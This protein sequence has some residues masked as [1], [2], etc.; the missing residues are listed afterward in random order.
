[1]HSPLLTREETT[2]AALSEPL[3]RAIALL[4]AEPLRL[5]VR[6]AEH[7]LRDVETRLG[8]LGT[9][10][11]DHAAARRLLELRDDLSSHLR[12]ASICTSDELPPALIAHLLR[13]GAWVTRSA[14]AANVSVVASAVEPDGG[15]PVPTRSS[16]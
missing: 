14:I 16:S 4:D 1:M 15:P 12:A 10:H 7:R 6:E 8:V 2:A 5:R 3:D 11:A 9:V 13:R